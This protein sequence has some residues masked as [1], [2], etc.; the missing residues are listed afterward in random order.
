MRAALEE[1][2]AREQDEDAGL[3]DEQDAEELGAEVDGAEAAVPDEH[4]A[5]EGDGQPGDVDARRG[6]AG[7]P[8]VAVPSRP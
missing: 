6:R 4:E 1:D 3:G 7:C 8:A 2:A 5:G